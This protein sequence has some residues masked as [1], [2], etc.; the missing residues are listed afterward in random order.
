MLVGS[1][2]G[3]SLARVQY[4]R[5]TELLQAIP[6]TPKS[7]PLPAPLGRLSVQRITVVPP[8]GNN[9]VLGQVNFELEQGESLGIIGPSGSGKSCLARA[10]L[11]IWPVQQGKVRLDGADISA[12]DRRNL[13][14]HIG[15]LP[16]D[17]ELFDGSVSENIC[18]FSKVDSERV[19]EAA[20][21][22]GVH[23]L[24]LKLPYGYDTEIAG[25]SGLL[26]GGHRQR[27]GLARALYGSP[28]LLVLDEPN[29]NLDDQGEKELINAMRE[30]AADRATL[31]V[32]THRTKLLN[33]VDKILVMSNGIMKFYGLRDEVLAAL[34]GKKGEDKWPVSISGPVS[35]SGKNQ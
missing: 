31:A 22:A 10:L 2:K 11:G 8:G 6:K 1:W 26:S 19:I 35:T 14:P 30:I 34:R 17:I 28:R 20:K 27:I 29:S 13:G 23:E 24:I 12:W 9:P 7:M 32:I 5:L 16:Q 18:R 33:S 21:K 3:F 25:S 15:Y 4:E